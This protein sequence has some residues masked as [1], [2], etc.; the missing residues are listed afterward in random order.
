MVLSP[1][2]AYLYIKSITFVDDFFVVTRSALPVYSL[3]RLQERW[4]EYVAVNCHGCGSC[5][6]DT[7][8]YNCDDND[9]DNNN[10]ASSE[11]RR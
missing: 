8:S 6:D 10:T 5:S 2:A 3:H 11:R 9:N 7:G 1:A 4:H